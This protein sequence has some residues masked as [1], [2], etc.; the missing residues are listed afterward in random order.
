MTKSARNVDHA[1]VE[2]DDV[3]ARYR[4]NR[5]TPAETD[6]FEIHYLDC[7]TC[8][9]MLEADDAL[10]QGFKSETAGVL[11]AAPDIKRTAPGR[12]SPSQPRWLA[13]YAIAATVLLATTVGLLTLQSVGPRKMAAT[14]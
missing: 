11:S 5:L 3:V 4:T 14:Q 2:S 13:P 9:A 1:F 10:A 7:A 12:R 6:A 8:R